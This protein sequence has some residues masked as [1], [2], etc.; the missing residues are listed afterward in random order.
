MPRTAALSHQKSFWVVCDD[1]NSEIIVS[2]TQTISQTFG[3]CHITTWPRRSRQILFQRLRCGRRGRELVGGMESKSRSW[4]LSLP[5]K[6]KSCP[7]SHAISTNYSF[8]L[9]NPVVVEAVIVGDFVPQGV[10]D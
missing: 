9:A 1:E 4:C 10:L 2:T 7:S 5:P 6:Y 8:Q 3:V